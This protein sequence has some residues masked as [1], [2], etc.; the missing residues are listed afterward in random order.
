MDDST[1][2][3]FLSKAF[4]GGAALAGGSILWR[5]LSA[6]AAEDAAAGAKRPNFIFIFADDMGWGDLSCYGHRELKTPHLDKLASQGALFSQF[7]VNAPLCSPSRAA[8]M[9]G[10]FPAEL[11]IHGAYAWAKLNRGR[12]MPDWLDPATPMLTRALQAN[13]Y[14]VGHFGKWHLGYIKGA[15]TPDKYGIDDYRTCVSQGKGWEGERTDPEFRAKST[16]LFVDET[17]RFIRSSRKADPSKPFYVNLWTLLPHSILNPTDEQLEPFRKYSTDKTRHVGAKPIWYATMTDLD[18]QIGRLMKALDEMGLAEDTVVIFSSDN[19]P[20]RMDNPNTNH[21][22]F[23]STGPFRGRKRSLYEG[24]VRMPF[25]VRY[26]RKIKAGRIDNDSI[27]SGVDLVP[28][29]CSLAG[30]KV[31]A[32]LAA[33]I[34]GEDVSDILTTGKSRARKAPLMWQ[35]RFRVPGRTID[36]SPQLAIREGKWKLLFN[37]DGSRVELYDIPKDPSE[38]DNLA[39]QNADVVKR[40]RAKALAWSKTLPKGRVSYDAGSN[41]YRWPGKPTELEAYRAARRKKAK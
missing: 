26:P 21:S 32:D 8:C 2:R 35:Y 16:G 13:G 18:T 22:A 19:G 31:P 40:L 20:A 11:S 36:R 24:G 12:T 14:A 5:A 27:I 25:I 39:G 29:I 7:Y 33:G 10:R 17:I 3:E 30:V 1:R 4:V 38:L 28:T 37:P 9:T 23:G 34:D 15:P 6:G 41:Y